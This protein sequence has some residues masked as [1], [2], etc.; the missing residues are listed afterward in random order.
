MET[1]LELGR[2]AALIKLAEGINPAPTPSPAPS[3]TGGAG[4]SL[5][6][7]HMPTGGNSGVGGFFRNPA[8]LASLLGASGNF[9][10]GFVGMTGAPGLF[11]VSNLARGGGDL[12]SILRGG[13]STGQQ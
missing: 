13:I 5:T 1:A 8:N 2:S 11:A 4:L 6:M 9:G 7:P 3:Q 12:G 10:R